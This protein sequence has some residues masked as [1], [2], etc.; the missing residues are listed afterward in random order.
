MNDT[1]WFICHGCRT[2]Q[3]IESR[4]SPDMCRGC[5]A[6]VERMKDPGYRKQKEQERA[7]EVSRKWNKLCP[8]LYRNTDVTLLNQTLL[9]RVMAWKYGPRGLVLS[10]DTGKGK[11]RTAYTLLRRL[12]FKDEIVAT[13]WDTGEW[14]N[15]CSRRFRIGE[16]ETFVADQIRSKLLYLDDFGNEASGERGEGELFRLLKR[17]GE[18]CLPTILTTQKMGEAFQGKF[19]DADRAI[20]I[21]RRLG[22]FC[23]IIEF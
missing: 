8:P 16:G 20:A 15:E 19:R 21:V 2:F 1:E 17:R 12:L 13:A 11:S 14:V 5:A 10:G 7:E 22:E 23:D 9:N 18:E 3:R 6:E 4:V